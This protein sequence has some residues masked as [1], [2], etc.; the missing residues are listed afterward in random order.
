MFLA[1][2][3]RGSHRGSSASNDALPPAESDRRTY[4]RGR[5]SSVRLVPTRGWTNATAHTVLKCEKQG[6]DDAPT[7]LRTSSGNIFNLGVDRLAKAPRSVRADVPT[8][9][10]SQSVPSEHD[11]SKP[12]RD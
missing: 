2:T 12:M 9:T 11:A 4:R 7:T 3:L 10:L 8:A 1:D 5:R 6:C